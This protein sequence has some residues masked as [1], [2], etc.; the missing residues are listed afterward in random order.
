M[1]PSRDLIWQ[2][3]RPR[4]RPKGGAPRR[5]TPRRRRAHRTSTKWGRS[6]PKASVTSNLSHHAP[7]RRQ[8]GTSPPTPESGP[9]RK[10][11]TVN[12]ARATSSGRSGQRRARHCP[13]TIPVGAPSTGST[14]WRRSRGGFRLTWG[15][16]T[17]SSPTSS[18]IVPGKCFCS[19]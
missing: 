17:R 12:A 8:S 4:V 13:V 18:R 19:W 6:R 5:S 1:A 16:C 10:S 2:A 7:S 14:C 15:T 9:R 11:T 3:S